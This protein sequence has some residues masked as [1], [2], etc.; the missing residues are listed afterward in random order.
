MRVLDARKGRSIK[1]TTP[2][3]NRDGIGLE[4]A[5]ACIRDGLG[6]RLSVLRPLSDWQ[7]KS[8]CIELGKRGYRTGEPAGIDCETSVVWRKVLSHLWSERTTKNDIAK[9]LNLPLDEFEGLIWNLA[10]PDIHP[11]K[12]EEGGLRAVK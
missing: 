10:G 4:N 3:H 11:A 9:Q 6:Y 12:Q 2:D 5:V 1:S 7:Y 8:I